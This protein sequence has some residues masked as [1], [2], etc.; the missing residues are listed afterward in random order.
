LKRL[1]GWPIESGLPSKPLSK[2]VFDGLFLNTS[3]ETGSGSGKPLLKGK[4]Y[5]LT[6]LALPG[7]RF[8]N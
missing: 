3:N 6:S 8:A 5:N 2:R 7:S 1:V 4:A